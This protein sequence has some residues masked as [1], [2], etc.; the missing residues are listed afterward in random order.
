MTTPSTPPALPRVAIVLATLLLCAALGAPALAGEPEYRTAELAGVELTYAVVMPD[1]TSADATHPVLLALPPGKQ[2]RRMTDLAL[3]QFWQFVGPGR[4][5]I[6]VSPVAPEGTLF[7]GDGK[8]PV[9]ALAEKLIDEMNPEG[10]KLHLAGVSNGGKAAFEVA[11]AKPELFHSLTALPGVPSP[12]QVG[13][14]HTLAD[15]TVRLFVGELDDG[16]VRGV[17]ATA[18]KLADAGVDV[19]VTM[20]PGEEHTLRS[21]SLSQLFDTLD[22]QRV[23][24]PASSAPPGE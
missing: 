6:V 5:W 7:M 11:L 19:G 8:A 4:G 2:S 15:M 16:W 20:V 23:R 13:E 14:L 24:A 18:A 12:E 3:R 1:E 10:G 9:L 22:A 17:E 21:L